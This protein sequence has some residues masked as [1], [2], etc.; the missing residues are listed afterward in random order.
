MPRTRKTHSPSESHRKGGSGGA[1]AG[2]GQA[3]WGSQL[4]VAGR[5]DEWPQRVSEEG[6]PPRSF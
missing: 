2:A 3:A 1:D 4:L 5:L 6:S